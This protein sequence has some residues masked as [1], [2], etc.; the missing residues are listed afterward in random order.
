[1]NPELMQR[2]ITSIGLLGIG[3]LLYSISSDFARDIILILIIVGCAF[4]SSSLLGKHF[5][6]QL[7]VM[8]LIAWAFPVVALVVAA[9]AWFV[10]FLDFWAQV[11]QFELLEVNAYPLLQSAVIYGAYWAFD[12]SPGHFFMAI[13]VAVLLDVFAY[14]GGRM[15][16]K[17]KNIIVASPNKS[18]EGFVVGFL[19]GSAFGVMM[20]LLVW[21]A[22]LMAMMA[23]IGD[24]WASSIKRQA[25]VK[26]SGYILP[27]HGGIL[28]R[29]DSWLPCLFLVVFF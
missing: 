21:Q 10:I 11:F 26:D 5:V 13:A 4:E 19:A 9:L 25:N 1:M 12:I 29:T 15:F 20:G 3:A 8:I 14:L 28:D 18:L 17:H 27:G 23:I 6:A 24:A 2:A 22:A 7:F 16:G